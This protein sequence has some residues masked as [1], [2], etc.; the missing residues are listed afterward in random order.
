MA[1]NQILA[2]L[3]SFLYMQYKFKENLYL[4]IVFRTKP[5]PKGGSCGTETYIYMEGGRFPRS[6]YV[7]VTI[8]VLLSYSG[9]GDNLF[10]F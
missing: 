7:L 6:L 9:V 4:C 10:K 3:Q 2:I 8:F 5:K 1:G